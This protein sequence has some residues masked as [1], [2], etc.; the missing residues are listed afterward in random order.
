MSRPDRAPLWAQLFRLD[1]DGPLTIQAQLR[2]Q[3]VAA[4][5]AGRLP[6]EDA[7]PSSRELAQ[8]LGIARNSVVGA[9]A[10]LA[11]DGYLEARQRRGYFINPLALSARPAVTEAPPVAA[12]VDWSERFRV[13]PS[14]QR[15]IS[16][17]ADWE[18]YEFPFIYGQ[19]DPSV[20]PLADW[21]AC[22][23]EVLGKGGVRTWAQDL[24]TR[25]DPALIEELRNKV[26][27]L[28]GVWAA[29]D[30]IIVT[31]GAQQAL[32]LLADLLF[33]AETDVGLENPGYP[34]ARNIFSLRTQRLRPLPVDAQGL[35]IGAALK[36]CR[37]V[38]VTPSHQAPTTV[39][40]PVDRR[41]ELLRRADRDDF[42]IIEDDYET[43]TTFSGLPNPALK[44]LD[45]AGRVIYVGS[46]SKSF[47]PGIRL[48]YIVAPKPL[49]EELRALR[50]LNIR[51]PSAFTQRSIARFVAL[52]HYDLLSRRL[53]DAHRERA[54]ILSAAVAE[55]GLPAAHAPVNGGSSV[56]FEGPEW[57]DARV[58][59]DAARQDGIL[60][61]PGDVH[62][63]DEHP[64]LNRFRLGYTSIPRSRIREGVRRL[65]QVLSRLHPR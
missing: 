17:V 33:D 1:P 6:A 38:Y 12:G 54:R 27:P 62:Y 56:W 52:G 31:I 50:R 5:A 61:E 63:M 30:E 55:F 16:K 32:Y 28:R 29:A 18:T 8:H 37:Y 7:M 47:A 65:T 19:F 22:C 15:N 34:D 36:H 23:Q 13:R 46:L 48:G 21:R 41:V 45:R 51:H 49:I 43:E 57:L 35:K 3:I 64:P 26:L 4:I 44:S 60:I 14:G 10:Q 53:V 58:L 25:D 2:A 20:F 59:A 39:T 40:M 42:L 11:D 24:F 9:Y